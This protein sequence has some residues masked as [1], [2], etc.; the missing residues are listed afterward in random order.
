[1]VEAAKY[2]GISK[3]SVYGLFKRYKDN[4]VIRKGPMAGA[5]MTMISADNYC[6]EIARAQKHGR[7]GYRPGSG[8]RPCRVVL[9]DPHGEKKEYVSIARAAESGIISETSLMRLNDG[10]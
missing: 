10:D 5:R 9:T 4:G 1:M 7:G 3:E 2:A 8:K 6:L